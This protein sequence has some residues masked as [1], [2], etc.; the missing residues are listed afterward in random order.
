MGTCCPPGQEG[1]WQPSS[2]GGEPTHALSPS[3]GGATRVQFKGL[4]R[5]M[6]I[7]IYIYI[8]SICHPWARRLEWMGARI[9]W[10]AVPVFVCV[11]GCGAATH[12]FRLANRGQEAWNPLL[13]THPIATRSPRRTRR[14][15][16]DTT[17]PSRHA[18]H[19]YPLLR[20]IWYTQTHMSNNLRVRY[21]GLRA[22]HS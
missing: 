21:V 2:I 17:Y 14:S 20:G 18:P 19:P 10:C 12:C 1:R 6:C 16:P 22:F 5:P 3:R 9:D 7:Y 15:P 11:V 13:T 4:K 8:Y